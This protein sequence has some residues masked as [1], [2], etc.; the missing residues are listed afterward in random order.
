MIKHY[1]AIKVNG[2]KKD[3]HRHIMEV[4]LGRSLTSNEVVHHIDENK[5]N[6]D[7]SN[8]VVMSRMEH[9]KMHMLHKT[10]SAI[11]MEK[12]RLHGIKTRPK[13]K[14]TIA[15]VKEIRSLLKQGERGANIAR[16]YGVDKKCVSDIKLGKTYY[17]V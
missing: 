13:A 11:T 4:H 10:K 12:L 5:H 2:K 16:S 7:L 1:K 9:T 15:Q 17:W 6:N 8:L 14:L 3:E